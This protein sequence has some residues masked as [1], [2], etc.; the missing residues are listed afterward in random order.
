MCSKVVLA[1]ELQL[2]ELAHKAVRGGGG[3]RIEQRLKVAV[4]GGEWNS[5]TS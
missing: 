2:A 4:E 1:G 3:V 5:W